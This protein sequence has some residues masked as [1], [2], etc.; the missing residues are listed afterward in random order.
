MATQR[1]ILHLGKVDAG[2]P[3]SSEDFAE[4]YFDEPWK[5]ERVQGRLVVL[6]P[7]GEGHVNQSEPWRDRLGAYRLTHPAVLQKVVSEAWIRV[8]DGTDRIGDIG[9][10]L[11]PDGPVAKIPDRVPDM[12]FEVVSPGKVSRARDYVEKRADYRRFGVREYVVIDRFR[13]TVTVLTLEPAG[14]SER[15][16]SVEDSYESPLLPGLVVPL[17]EVF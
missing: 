4:A 6:P 1:T 13:R 17:S 8:D 2:R 9:V 15:I 5:Y 10:Y 12:M 14:Y 7:S 3:V 11:V 16:L